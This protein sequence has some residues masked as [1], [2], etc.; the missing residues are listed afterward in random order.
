MRVVEAA[1]SA[2][3]TTEQSDERVVSLKECQ[4]VA[5]KEYGKFGRG[6]LHATEALLKHLGIKYVD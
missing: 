3:R 4:E 5:V 2:A 6:V 1:W